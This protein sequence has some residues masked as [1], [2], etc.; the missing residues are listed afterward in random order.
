M[1][2]II[3]ISK[4]DAYLVL[5]DKYCKDATFLDFLFFGAIL[6][7]IGIFLTYPL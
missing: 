7:A 6:M 3:F 1:L 4:E 5:F 2:W